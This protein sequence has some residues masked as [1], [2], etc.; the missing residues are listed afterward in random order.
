M[1]ASQALSHFEVQRFMQD[2]YSQTL[3]FPD[4]FAS[5][6]GFD[7]EYESYCSFTNMSELT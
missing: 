2:Q 5:L 3:P 7:A 6:G 1:T 4:V